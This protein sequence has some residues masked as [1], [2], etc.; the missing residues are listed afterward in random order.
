LLAL[1]GDERKFHNRITDLYSHRKWGYMGREVQSHSKP[2]VK[3][4]KAY[5][6][7]IA[8]ARILLVDDFA[9]WRC[10]IRSKLETHA[11]FKIV[12]EA[13]NGLEAVRKAQ[14]LKPDLVFMDVGL[15]ILNGIEAASRIRETVPRAKILFLSQNNDRNLVNM[16]LNDGATGYVLKTDV[17]RELLPAADAVLRGEKFVSSQLRV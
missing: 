10:A 14:Q 15:P 6:S 9:E 12:A 11:R 16:V 7:S 13:S 2:R 1:S 8:G 3:V 17:G 4:A 5:S